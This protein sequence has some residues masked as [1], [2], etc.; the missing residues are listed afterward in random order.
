MNV[1]PV[2]VWPYAK[3]VALYPESASS[4]TGSAIVSN[5]SRCV[6]YWPNTRSNANVFVTRFFA[7]PVAIL[8]VRD[9]GSVVTI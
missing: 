4:T 1:L 6:E 8:T 9:E 3:M 7:G 2:P 5:T